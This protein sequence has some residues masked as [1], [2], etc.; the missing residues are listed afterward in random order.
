MKPVGVLGL[1]GGY[2]PHLRMLSTLG[3]EAHKVSTL[4]EIDH[5]SGLIIPGGESTTIGKLLVLHNLLEPL[6]KKIQAGLC[7]FGTCAGLILL[8]H[9]AEGSAQPLLNVLDVDV[10]RNAYGRQIYS[11]EA[12]VKLQGENLPP[13]MAGIFIRAP[14]ITRVGSRVRILASYEDLPVAVQ[15]EN[16]LAASF[17]PELTQDTALH[18]AFLRLMKS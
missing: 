1:Q 9:Q 2:D 7:V 8:S 14:Q 16:I 15:Q 18:Q 6:R 11:F 10:K 3:V 17:H 13:Y 5:I 4:E 12:Q